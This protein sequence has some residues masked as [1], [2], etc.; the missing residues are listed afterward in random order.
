MA[1]GVAEIRD[2]AERFRALLLEERFRARAGQKSWAEV[3]PLYAAE[4]ILHHPDALPAIER[5]LASATGEEERRLRRLLAF[6]AEHRLLNAN[7]ALDDEFG[8]W[9]ST[10]SLEIGGVDLPLSQAAFAV[11]GMEDREERRTLERARAAALEEA[12]PLQLDRLNRWRVAAKELGYGGYL[13]AAERI[14]GFSIRGLVHEMR[15]VLAETEAAYRRQLAHHLRIHLGIGPEEAEGHDALRLSRMAWLDETGDSVS[16]L[17]L[18]RNDLMEMEL[19]MEAG[20]RLAL[21]VEAFPGPGMRPYAA[22]V[23]VPDRILLLA[24]PDTT[25]P[26]WKALLLELGRAVHFAYTDPSLGFEDR[27]LGDVAVREASGLLFERLL[28]APSWVERSRHLEASQL[29][30][31]LRL[32]AFIELFEV[33]REVARLEFELELC[34]SDRPGAMGVRWAEIL[35]AATGFRF[36]PRA[37]LEQLGQRFGVATRLRARMLAAQLGRELRER[38]DAEWHRNPRA[39]EFLR[40]WFAASGCR[41]AAELSRSLECERLDAGALTGTILAPLQ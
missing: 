13:D 23:Y 28:H 37:F 16:I 12:L 18:V 15:K 41:D 39:G 26:I 22:P 4:P 21:H 19:P 27:A 17:D 40:R 36:D 8:F 35:E 3:A 9:A 38:F 6:T 25:Q 30:E 34:E 7:A 10:A 5:C 24:T 20:G 29:E 2:R 33:R 32:A 31:Y 1:L 11:E 14:H